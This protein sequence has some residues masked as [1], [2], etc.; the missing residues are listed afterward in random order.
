MRGAGSLSGQHLAKVLVMTGIVQHP[1]LATKAVV[2]KNTRTCQRVMEATSCQRADVD[3]V[4]RSVA[5]AMA[6]HQMLPRIRV[7]RPHA[8]TKSM[9]CSSL[10]KVW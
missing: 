6:Q 8:H 10:D 9:T 1:V 5:D 3:V 7:V 2:A 4:L